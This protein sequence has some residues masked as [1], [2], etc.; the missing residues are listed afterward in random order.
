MLESPSCKVWCDVPHV[1]SV[2]SI[3]QIIEKKQTN[4]SPETTILFFTLRGKQQ[5]AKRNVSCV[6]IARSLP[7]VSDKE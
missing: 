7:L 5:E 3:K 1:E 2:T 4:I 6:T